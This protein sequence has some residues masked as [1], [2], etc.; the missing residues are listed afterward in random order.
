MV[1]KRHV[2][3]RGFLSSVSND[4][5]NTG[6][7]CAMAWHRFDEICWTHGMGDGYLLSQLLSQPAHWEQD[8]MAI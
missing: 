7:S 2:S 5:C 1:S 3:L 8:T 6:H 4:S